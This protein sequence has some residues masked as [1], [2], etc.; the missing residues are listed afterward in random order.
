MSDLQIILERSKE[1][2]LLVE[3]QFQKRSDD[4]LHWKESEKKWS[5]IEVIAH[6]NLIY[7]CY[8]P[9]FEVALRNAK[10]REEGGAR[11]RQQS[12][13]LGKLSIY[14]MK[15]KG[16]KRR[17]KMATFDFFEP[18]L[19]SGQVD[20]TLV[21]FLENK[22]QF[23]GFVEESK[24]LDIRDIKVSTALGERVKFYL[25]ECFDFIM[26]HEERHVVQIQEILEKAQSNH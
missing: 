18:N 14:S 7:E 10:K 22:A 17:F 12:T 5:V 11:E 23:E 20:V 26:S 2:G 8:A 16:S 21:D 9:K 19:H 25:P 13:I 3:N 24:H 6:L 4:I 15:P 1:V